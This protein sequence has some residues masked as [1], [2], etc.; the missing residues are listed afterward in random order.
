MALPAVD[1]FS[2]A[3]GTLGPNWHG[4]CQSSGL[5]AYGINGGAFNADWWTADAFNSDHYSQAGIAG[6][7]N[8]DNAVAVR[9]QDANNFYM[10]YNPSS[11]GLSLFIRNGGSFT[12]IGSIGGTVIVTDTIKLEAIGTS[13]HCYNNGVE[14]SGS[15]FTDA[16]FS[17]GSAGIICFNNNPLLGL[18]NFRADNVGAPGVTVK[19]LAALGV[20]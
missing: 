12:N 19:Q 4:G 7:A 18:D 16:T 1:S 20:G 15:P 11:G 10:L 17:G 8:A 3:G 14:L 9:I 2:V 6:T 13:L 5:F